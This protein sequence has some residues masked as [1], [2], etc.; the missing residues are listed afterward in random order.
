MSAAFA[1]FANTQAFKDFLATVM[2]EA[3]MVASFLGGALL[4]VVGPLLQAL[5]P[6]GEV[7]LQ[8]LTPPA[9]GILGQLLQPLIPLF[10]AISPLIAALVPPATLITQVIVALLVPVL[11]VLVAVLTAVITWI[12]DAVNWL[13][14]LATGNQEAGDQ[15]Q[16][17]W[18]AVMSFF[19]GVGQFFAGIWNGLV[20][21]VSNMVSSVVQWFNSL[22][23]R[24]WAS[25]PAPD[26][27][28]STRALRSCRGCGMASGTPGTGSWAGSGA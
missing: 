6:L 12:T 9:L 11:Q 16:A 19:A 27:G 14:K 28:C 22:P 4:A 1:D 25:S 15:L 10:T 21:G 7:I 3:P 26:N 2:K 20:Q 8:L 13:V 18:G 17:V 24:S 23:A 5:A